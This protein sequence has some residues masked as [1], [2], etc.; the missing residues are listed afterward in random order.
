MIGNGI[1]DRVTENQCHKW[2]RICSFLRKDNPVLCPFLFYRRICNKSWCHYW[3]K[4]CLP[5]QSTQVNPRFWWDSHCPICC[6]RCS[7]L[8]TIVCPFVLF[9]LIISFSV[10][11]RI[12]ALSPFV[13]LNFSYILDQVGYKCRLV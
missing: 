11:L 1:H 3:S 5:F 10:F 12:A 6:F 4:N 2:P 8:L 13:Y 7:I 9:L